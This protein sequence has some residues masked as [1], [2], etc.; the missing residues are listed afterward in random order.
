MHFVIM[1]AVYATHQLHLFRLYN[2]NVS[3]GFLGVCNQMH[4]VLFSLTVIIWIFPSFF[5]LQDRS[6]LQTDS[7][8]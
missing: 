7:C 8:R 5:R 1:Q 3:V 6:L 2:Q 4:C